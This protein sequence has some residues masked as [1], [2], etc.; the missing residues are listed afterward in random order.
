[1]RPRCTLI[2]CTVVV[3]ACSFT[4][5][6]SGT[7]A[8]VA[9]GS[10]LL[11]TGDGKLSCW[12]EPASGAPGAIRFED[13][14]DTMGLVEPLIGIH[15]HAAAFGE[16]NDDGIADLVVGTFADRE[17][18]TYAVRG[19]EGPAPDRLLLS[20]PSLT[21]DS[22]WSTELG[23]TSG[24]VFAD[25]DSDEDD[26]LL[27][28]RHA[29]RQE[30][31]P[32]PSRLFENVDGALTSHSEPLPGD[33]RGR[34]PAVADFDGDGLLDVYIS[35][36]EP[37][38]SGG[39][40]LHNE[41]YLRLRD[42]TRGS[43]LEGVISLGAV[44]GDLNHDL[45]PDLITSTEVFINRGGMAF[46]QITPDGYQAAPVGD[47]DD[48]AGV[49]LGDLDRDGAVDI[50]IGQHYRS[51]VEGDSEI[52]VRV[53]L[54]SGDDDRPRFVDATD[55]TGIS[56]LPTLAPHVAVADLDNDGWLDIVTTASARDGTAPA[57]Y[58]NAGRGDLFFD[59]SPGLGSD[60]Y[61]IGGPVADIDHDGRLDILAVEWEP[62]LPSIMF[63]NTGDT[64]HWLEV[65]LGR[66]GKGVGSKITVF[67]TDGEV[68]GRQEIAV[69]AGY[70]SGQLP[71]AHFGVGDLIAVDIT[72]EMTD[73]SVAELDDVPVDQ[74]LR[75]P[76]GC[77]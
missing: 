41:G 23:R 39:L 17:P 38:E 48:P 11:S 6:D 40:L 57:V 54:N 30:N 53:L 26:D 50:V 51:A 44:A 72:I 70:A 77:R 1:M 3:T 8:T 28:V 56:P 27:L 36:D 16:V 13:A 42:V 15:G 34:T 45:K 2:L 43:G 14:T 55:R 66:P 24:A 7:T 76:E 47:D 18:A 61:W 46:E 75:W 65:S 5:T 64:G 58:R 69:S 49:A 9:G 33:F 32:V 29:G 31:H 4:T 10:S 74:H 21:L 12:S 35:E 71:I 59:V 73:G 52:P 60:Q 37:G 19:A 62:S 63:R 68:L 20:D 22:D 25:F 67:G